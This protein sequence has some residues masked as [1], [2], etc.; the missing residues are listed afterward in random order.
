MSAL[1]GALLSDVLKWTQK[2]VLSRNGEIFS[3]NNYGSY[4]MRAKPIKAL[5]LVYPMIQV[6]IK[7]ISPFMIDSNL[8]ANSSLLTVAEHI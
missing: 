6:F 3:T 4:S 7:N 2:A 5:E 8:R 1:F